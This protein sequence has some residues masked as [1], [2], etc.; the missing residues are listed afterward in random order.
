[1]PDVDGEPLLE[2][3]AA[4]SRYVVGLLWD[5]ANSNDLIDLATAGELPAVARLLDQ[6]CALTGGAIAEFPSVTLVNHTSALTGVGPARHG[7][8]HNTFW[9]RQASR[10][11]V[12]NDASTWH[13]ACD[14]L[15][16]AC[17]TVFEVLGGPTACV[18][19]PVD[20]G[21]DVLHLRVGARQRIRRTAPRD[22]GTRCRIHTPIGTP[23]SIGYARIP[24]TPGRPRSTPSVWIRCCSCGAMSPT[25][26]A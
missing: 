10:Q 6:G 11:V 3:V 18:N 4:G 16:P 17:A 8:L 20:R 7:I 15:R 13:K 2:L 23:A 26:P 19:E 12:A 21:A 22:C 14:L 1:M 5:G 24:I 9:D 25:H